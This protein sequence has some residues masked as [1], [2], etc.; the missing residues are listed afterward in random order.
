MYVANFSD[1]PEIIKKSKTEITIKYYTHSDILVLI[2]DPPLGNL[3]IFKSKPI[4][5]IFYATDKLWQRQFYPS[6]FLDHNDDNLISNRV[7]KF[8]IPWFLDI[9]TQYK[10]KSSLENSSFKILTQDG[11]FTKTNK[12]VI[13]KEAN[14]VEFCFTKSKLHMLDD[15]TGIIKKGSYMFEI[16]ISSDKS[17]IKKIIKGYEK[18]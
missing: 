13:I 11:V 12:N 6:G 1:K 18:I 10:I 8:Y 16:D 14:F 2:P 15:L 5:A 9:D 7:Y 3:G 4:Y 17:T